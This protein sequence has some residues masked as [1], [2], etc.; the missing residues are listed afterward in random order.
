MPD[1][2]IYIH[3]D[4]NGES[5]GGQTKPYQNS[6]DG[7][8]FSNTKPSPMDVINKTQDVAQHGFGSLIN[9]GVAA[10]SKIAPPVAIAV[11]I[12]K[13]TDK[14]L[15]TGFAHQEK[16]NGNYENS[17]GYNNFKTELGNF[18]NPMKYGYTMVM[19]EKEFELQNRGTVQQNRLVGSSILKDMKRGV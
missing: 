13:A 17:V 14:V 4:G 19:R 8:A 16:W 2:H 18:I 15:T 9:T 7:T 1:Y 5:I 3:G 6:G 10:L 12:I 11:A